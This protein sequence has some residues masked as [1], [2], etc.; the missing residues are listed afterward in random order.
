M[1]YNKSSQKIKYFIKLYY[2][3]LFYLTD[4]PMWFIPT[5]K[6]LLQVPIATPRHPTL[7]FHLSHE[8]AIHNKEILQKYGNSI[9]DY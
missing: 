8:A 2:F 9:H 1:T 7:R 4:H 3:I 6:K 5:I